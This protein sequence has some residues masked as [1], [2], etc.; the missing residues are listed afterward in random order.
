MLGRLVDQ[1][2]SQGSRD[3]AQGG[4]LR[5]RRKAENQ[6]LR[7]AAE[8]KTETSEVPPPP[9]DAN[10]NSNS[11]S[12]AL[13]A[14]TTDLNDL[15][16]LHEALPPQ[17]LLS[18]HGDP[19][20]TSTLAGRRAEYQ[21]SLKRSFFF[22][23]MNLEFRKIICFVLVQRYLSAYYETTDDLAIAKLLKSSRNPRGSSSV[24][25]PL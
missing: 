9:P 4:Q 18:G 2:I 22:L 24:S 25:S 15:T 3:H 14:A 6:N 1:P 21:A 17:L 8:T 12:N 20:S 5:R 16:T 10:S 7:D 13:F 19:R 23:G 11:N